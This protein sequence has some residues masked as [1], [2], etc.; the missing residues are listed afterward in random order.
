MSTGVW[1]GTGSLGVAR[2]VWEGRKMGEVDARQLWLTLCTTADASCLRRGR[3]WLSGPDDSVRGR[4]LRGLGA[5]VEMVTRILKAGRMHGKSFSCPR[6][7]PVGD[8]LRRYAAEHGGVVPTSTT[9]VDVD[10]LFCRFLAYLGAA[11]VS[12][13]ADVVK[14]FVPASYLPTLSHVFRTACTELAGGNGGT[15]LTV[16]ALEQVCGTSPGVPCKPA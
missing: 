14:T 8:M 2:G 1:D 6:T 12:D 9:A 4:N 3:R 13:W 15:E 11:G 7:F 16:A 10:G 5:V